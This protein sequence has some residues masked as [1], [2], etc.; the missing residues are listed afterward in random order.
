MAHASRG[1]VPRLCAFLAAETKDATIAVPLVL[2]RALHGFALYGAHRDVT[3][4]DPTERRALVELAR[5]ADLAYEHI[6]A[7]AME[8]ELI[9]LQ[10]LLA[11]R[12]A[13]A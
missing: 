8:K 3:R 11:S 7:P 5:S 10:A 12:P 9:R 1:A 13:T 2:R 6:A 4:I